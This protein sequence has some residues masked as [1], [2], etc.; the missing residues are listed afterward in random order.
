MLADATTASSA[1]PSTALGDVLLSK[2][3]FENKGSLAF[4]QL[5]QTGKL[6]TFTFTDNKMV[7]QGGSL[8]N[9]FWSAVEANNFGSVTVT[10][11]DVTGERKI[12]DDRGFLQTWSRSGVWDLNV[13][14]NKLSNFNLGYQLA[15]YSDGSNPFTGVSADSY[16]TLLASNHTDVDND[17][18]IGYPWNWST[19]GT[20]SAPATGAVVPQSVPADMHIVDSASDWISYTG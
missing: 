10:G 20:M 5:V 12:N 8:H 4:R 15:F 19:T 7:P 17:V 3:Y 14:N 11:N 16:V 9:L 6:G 1:T 18:S 2:C 13:S